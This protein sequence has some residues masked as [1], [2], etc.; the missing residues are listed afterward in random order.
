MQLRLALAARGLTTALVGVA[1][2]VRLAAAEVAA[3]LLELATLT[4]I[5]APP[6]PRAAL[7]YLG[8]AARSV[9]AALRAPDQAPPIGESSDGRHG[10]RGSLR[11]RLS[12]PREVTLLS[13]ERMRVLQRRIV[14][15]VFSRRFGLTVT[16]ED[17]D[18]LSA[19]SSVSWLARNLSA[20]AGYGARP[21]QTP[22]ATHRLRVVLPV[23][24]NILALHR[25]YLATGSS[26]WRSAAGEN[27]SRQ[28]DPTTGGLIT[29]E[30]YPH[31]ITAATLRH[32]REAL[33]NRDGHRR[34][35]FHNADLTLRLERH[36]NL[37]TLFKELD[38]ART[39]D[40][41]R[42]LSSTARMLSTLER[43]RFH[44]PG[45]SHVRMDEQ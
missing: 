11:L 18:V 5:A 38:E 40:R 33:E 17:L 22:E 7:S 6:S 1:F 19:Y 39:R 35:R 13:D 34:R 30:V 9:A 3:T 36:L 42:R 25:H 45:G 20:A 16:D 8:D 4:W 26:E 27:R 37:I 15:V 24:V 2:F 12:A 21:P 31:A 32:R 41:G 10:N 44:A 14:A 29:A 28:A 23:L 43:I